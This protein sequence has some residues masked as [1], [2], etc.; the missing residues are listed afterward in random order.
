[1]W[2][3]V[4]FWGALA[5]IVALLIAIRTL[6]PTRNIPEVPQVNILYDDGSITL[7][8]SGTGSA[9]DVR[10]YTVLYTIDDGHHIY[11]R[12][13]DAAPSWTTSSIPEAS[14]VRLPCDAYVNIA[15][16]KAMTYHPKSF[17]SP[18]LVPV[19]RYV[20][21]RDPAPR[22][23]YEIFFT[24]LAADNVVNLVPITHSDSFEIKGN[25]ALMNATLTE[26]RDDIRIKFIRE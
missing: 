22:Y 3:K 18:F 5:S 4:A 19:V 21:R 15:R 17:Q 12:D 23:S 24:L 25:S 10:F 8:N 2:N 11:N 26:I 6:I 1:M 13:A 16:M 14:S 20:G 7:T 9:Q